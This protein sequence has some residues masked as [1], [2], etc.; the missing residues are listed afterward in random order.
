MSDSKDM[1]GWSDARP[2]A[3]PRSTAWPAGMA[4]GI[5]LLIWGFVT[6]L[7]LILVGLVVMGVSLAGWIGEMRHE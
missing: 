1:T 6:S 5:T 2:E 7:V 3:I 4:F